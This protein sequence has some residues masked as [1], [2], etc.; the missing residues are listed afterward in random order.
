MRII[1]TSKYVS[2]EDLET[3]SHFDRE[4]MYN[5]LDCC[6]TL[7]ILE[8][9]L[10]EL[11]E[12]ARGTYNM[13]LAL[14]API[15]EMS[16]RGV[17][18]DERQRQKILSEKKQK[19]FELE[20]RLKNLFFRGLGLDLNY[21]S[22]KDMLYLFYEVLQIKPIRK[23]NASGKFVPTVDRDTIEKLSINYWALPL[24]AHIIALREL[25]KKISFLK[26]GIDA[27]GRMR[28]TFNIAG[29][30]T[31][32]LASS[33]SEFDTGSNMQNID[34]TLRTIFIPDAGKKFINIDLEQGDSRNLGALLWNIFVKSHGESFAGSY[35]TMCES[36]DLHTMVASMVWKNLDWPADRSD[37]KAMKAIAEQ[38]FYREDS[39]RQTS[40]KLGHGTNYDGQP[41]T[42][43]MH[44][45]MPISTIKE[46]QSDYFTAFPVIT[47]YHKW[48]KEQLAQYGSLT[49]LYNRR[50]FFFGRLSD[51]TTINE[52][53]AYPNQSATADAVNTAMLAIWRAGRAEILCQ[54]H[55]SLLMQVPEKECDELV[56][57]LLELGKSK[58][59]LAQ[60][61]EFIV[62]NEA[63]VGWNW[64]DFNAKD[65]PFG[66]IKYTGNDT[67][68]HRFIKKLS[69][70]NRR[71]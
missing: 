58:L 71:L 21:R 46:F 24:C 45:K 33:A 41:Y 53:V 10:D 16:L 52:A 13:S 22:P 3:L 28:S 36:G 8:V 57:E 4:S 55:D 12:I 65:N 44:T 64:G 6:V 11:D 42:M 43:A 56:P 2:E 29:T 67:R 40:K 18:V 34:R 23:R 70:I 9:L 60:G 25:D 38:S 51:K 14:R 59:T 1:D 61:R 49:T 5:G 26:V 62:P 31:G 69:I 20:Q 63:K 35:L 66:L 54:V 19:H 7:E 50:R 39:Y 68:D 48:V 27:D 47:A 32:R 37:M 15:L 30:N 17:R